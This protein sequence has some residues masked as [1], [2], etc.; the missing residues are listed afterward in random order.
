V[1]IEVE[2][3][4]RHDPEDHHDQG[5]GNDRRKLLERDDEHQRAEPDQQRQSA[6]PAELAE[7]GPQLLE[8]VP[9]AL[10]DAE[11][12]RQLSHDD[13]ECEPDD[14]PLEHG[15]GDEAREKA[16]AEETRDERGDP[17]DDPKRDRQLHESSEAP[18]ARSPTA[19]AD[20]A[21]VAAIGPVTRWRE[22]PKA[23]YRRS[24]PGAAYRPTTGETPAIVA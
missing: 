16:E 6:R 7:E 5:S 12:L 21:A 13:R 14:E 10:V 24:A 2:Q 23:A 11:Q 1:L 17:D 4:H 3:Q 22:L 15:L 18:A 8:E 19:A 9:L 20:R